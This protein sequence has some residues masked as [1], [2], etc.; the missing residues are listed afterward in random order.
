MKDFSLDWG[1]EGGG[2]LSPDW[3]SCRLPAGISGWLLCDE[4]VKEEE[5]V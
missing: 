4:R 1:Q 5:Q 3:M 2:G